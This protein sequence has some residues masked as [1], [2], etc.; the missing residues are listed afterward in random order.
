[1]S[2]EALLPRLAL[3][4]AASALLLAAAA[5]AV[6][7][8]GFSAVASPPRFELSGT[9]GSRTRQVVEITN[10]GVQPAKFRVRTADWSLAPDYSVTFYDE[11]RP[12]SCR[13]WVSIERPELSLAGG[14]RARFRFEVAP[15]PDAPVGECRFALLVEGDDPAVAATDLFKIPVRGRLGVIVY[16][17]IGDAAPKL[18]IV[19]NSVETVQGRRV[20]TLWVRNAGNAHGRL[21]GFLNGTDAKGRDLEF[22]PSSFPILPGETRPIALAAQTGPDAPV[23]AVLPVTVRGTI[24]W[25]GERIPFEHRFE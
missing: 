11:L 2:T 9:P 24:E 10:V 8:Q 4:R 15:P 19:R 13:P 25:A 18:E 21:A 17:A 6:H 22:S 7:A 20:P 3:T 16:L 23:D 14:A 12:G 5:A 1:M